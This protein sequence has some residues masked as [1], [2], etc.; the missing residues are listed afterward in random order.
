MAPPLFSMM[1][2]VMLTDSFKDYVAGFPIRCRFDGTVFNI[3]RL[4]ANS[5]E[6]TGVLYKFLYADDQTE[7]TKLER[8]MQVA[9]D[10]VSQTCGN[11]DPSISIKKTGVVYPPAHGKPYSEPTI[12]VNGQRQQIV[13]ISTYLGSAFFSA[14]Y[15]DDEII[16]RTAKASVVFGRLRAN[17][18][19]EIKQT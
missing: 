4:Q 6:Q 1:F 16:D 14:V 13:D 10:R 2:S 12:N 19:E 5:K 18:W 3:R 9:M 15:I 11:Y 7:N 17:I 8:K